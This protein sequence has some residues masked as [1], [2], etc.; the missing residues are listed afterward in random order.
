MT[1]S[2]IWAKFTCTCLPVARHISITAQENIAITL[3]SFSHVHLMLIVRIDAEG[4]V[5]SCERKL[6]T[7]HVSRES[8]DQVTY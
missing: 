7:K 1:F 8:C 5:F 3:G 2:A 6:L 4:L